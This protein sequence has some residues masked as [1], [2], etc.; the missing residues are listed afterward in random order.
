M[1]L[2][3]TFRACMNEHVWSLPREWGPWSV[4]A[5]PCTPRCARV[6]DV[7]ASQATTCHLLGNPMTGPSSKQKSTPA[8][9]HTHTHTHPVLTVRAWNYWQETRQGNVLWNSSYWYDVGRS[10]SDEEATRRP[11][12]LWLLWHMIEFGTSVLRHYGTLIQYL[13][14]ECYAWL[15][16]L[17]TNQLAMKWYVSNNCERAQLLPLLWAWRCIQRHNCKRATALCM[18]YLLLEAKVS[19]VLMLASR[20]FTLRESQCPKFLRSWACHSYGDRFWIW[21]E[22]SDSEYS[23]LVWSEATKSHW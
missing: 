21:E 4:R 10:G 17:Q 14:I 9:T 13:S 5:S 19:P 7:R 20:R 22:E 18:A 6:Q 11:K 3:S 1:Q 12:M 15:W 23:S 16:R 2:W 8:Y